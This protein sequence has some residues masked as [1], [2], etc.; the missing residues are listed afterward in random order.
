[1]IYNLLYDLASF[2]KRRGN[3][4]DYE[5]YLL[6]ILASDPVYGQPGAEP[7]FLK[8]VVKSLENGMDIDKFFMLYRHDF[9]YGLSAYV[10]LAE[11]YYSHGRIDRALSAAVLGA[12]TGFTKIA[13]AVRAKDSEFA[14]SGFSPMLEKMNKYEDIVEW[15][16]EN[17]VWES[18]YIFAEILYAYGQRQTAVDLF[19]ALSMYAPEEYWR[20][21]A[22]KQFIEKT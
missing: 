1:M 8:A 6:L 9:Y 2:A 5:K 7:P 12:L 19:R 4:G 13:E 11:F 14:Y 16:I 10:Q 22:L 18:M 20:Q 15:S 3:L 17:D 21:N